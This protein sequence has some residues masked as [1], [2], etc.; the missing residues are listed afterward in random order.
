VSTAFGSGPA[1][2]GVGQH[3]T[4][5]ERST[6]STEPMRR[7]GI[8]AAPRHRGQFG[9]RLVQDVAETLRLGVPPVPRMSRDV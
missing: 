3:R 2:G 7:V 1:T 9:A 4:P 5:N 6:S 8:D